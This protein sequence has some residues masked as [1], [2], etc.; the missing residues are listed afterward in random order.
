[1]TA[2]CSDRDILAIEPL[3]YLAGGFDTAQILR[4][5]SD[6]VLA[7]TTFT[8]ATGNF[9]TAGITPGMVLTASTNILPEG[10]AV[11]ILA[12]DSATQLSVSVLRASTDDSPVAPTPGTGMHYA[13]R[14]FAARIA[15]VSDEIA[16]TLRRLHDTDPIDPTAFTPN[17]QLRQAAACGT[18]AG[19]YLARAQNARP[20]DANWIKAE[21]YRLEYR[22]R[23]TTLRLDID[24]DGD[25]TPERTRSLGNVQLKRV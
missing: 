20:H 16:Q 15:L 11:E 21:Y 22:R 5:G 12:V 1:M 24:D 3:A 4:T 10:S 13:V 18:L 14:T 17:H 8:S 2:F 19:I 25:G 23:L 6:G 9:L 7:G